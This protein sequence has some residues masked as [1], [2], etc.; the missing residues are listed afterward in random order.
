MNVRAQ[1][2]YAERDVTK[3]GEPALDLLVV[4]GV[5]VTNWLI[6]HHNIMAFATGV[7]AFGMS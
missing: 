3:E 2:E 6:A 7:S 5:Y 1:L 4:F